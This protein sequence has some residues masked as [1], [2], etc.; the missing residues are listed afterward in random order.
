M[1]AFSGSAPGKVI[2]FGEHAVVYGQPAIAVP[3][4]QL[5]ARAFAKPLLRAPS[6]TIHIQADDIGL[7]AELASLDDSNPIALAIHLTLQKIGVERPLA[8]HLKVS[9]TIPLAAGLGSG[10]AISVAIIRAISAFHGKPLP[11][12]DVSALAFEVE[13]IY[14][15]TPS[16]IDNTV[17]TFAKPVYFV[18]GQPLQTFKVGAPFTL[19]IADTGIASPTRIAVGDVRSAWEKDPPR[20]DA[21]FMQIGALAQKA[22]AAIE[23]GDSVAL[24]P[25]MNENHALLQQIGVSSPE[26]DLLVTAAKQAGAHGA[27]LSGS[28]RGGNMIALVDEDNSETVKEALLAAEAK[29]V[30]STVVK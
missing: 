8:L 21:L 14:H 7:D 5:A 27:K 26:L 2:L 29:S 24:G 20:Y 28:G 18:K 30:I 9:S 22:R 16:G 15:G 6:G 1:P 23:T 4:Q 10:A 25:L 19:L 12:A 11:D 17:V 3:V 13:K